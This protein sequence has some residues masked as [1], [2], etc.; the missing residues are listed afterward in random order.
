MNYI[1]MFIIVLLVYAVYKGFTKG[2]IMQLT[3]LIAILLGIFGALKLSGFTVR[4]LGN[5]IHL[6]PEMMYITSLGLTFALVF[7]GVYLAGKL[8]EKLIKAVELSLVNRLLG[9]IFSV[10]KIVL[11]LGVLLSYV[12]RIDQR[13]H[14]LPKGSREYSIFY[15]PFTSIVQ[16]IFPALASPRSEGRTE[17]R[18]WV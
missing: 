17:G 3:I 9:V 4:Q 16:S 7:I 12:D 10:G 18:E 15:K 14:F 8:T 6:N 2:F 1:D 13:I 11:I 5:H